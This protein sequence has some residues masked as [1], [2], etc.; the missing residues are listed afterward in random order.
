MTGNL[1]ADIEALTEAA[2][3]KII[4]W[5]ID[6][7]RER[8]AMFEEATNIVI[9]R[10]LTDA[11]VVPLA[12]AIE[13]KIDTILAAAP[14]VEAA[15]RAQIAAEINQAATELVNIES[16]ADGLVS[17]GVWHNHDGLRTAARI[18]RGES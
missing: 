11:E 12:T 4:R 16:D 6:E 2:A 7:A 5:G 9:E 10:D 17:D 3:R 18:A 14:I 13:A 15:V 1:R 8:E